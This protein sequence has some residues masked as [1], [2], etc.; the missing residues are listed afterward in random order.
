MTDKV[1]RLDSSKFCDVGLCEKLCEKLFSVPI[2]SPSH[3]KER[4]EQEIAD[5]SKAV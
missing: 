5:V 4:I 3:M 2:Q 1:I